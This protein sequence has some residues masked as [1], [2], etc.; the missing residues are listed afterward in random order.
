[1]FFSA[2]HLDIKSKQ[3][4]ADF[5]SIG[6]SGKLIICDGIGSFPESGKVSKLVVDKFISG[7]YKSI[8]EII[9]DLDSITVK[10]F[11]GGTTLITA[12]RILKSDKVKFEYLGNGGIIQLHGDFAINP[13]TEYPYRYGE[14][15]IPHV[16][17]SGKLTRHISH[18]SNKQEHR[19]TKLEV[20]L[21]YHCGDI[22]ILFSDGLSSLEENIILKDK[23]S[24]YWRYEN[25]AIQKVL[26]ALHVF[27]RNN[28]KSSNFEHDLILFNENILKDLKT[29]GALD[30]DASL[31]II[32]TKSVVEYYIESNG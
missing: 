23:E 17:P 4:C 18:N 16:S 11:E 8:S 7:D 24:R 30:D 31:G 22:V 5:S 13:N 10:N 3:D 2:T 14:L 27:L 12:Q 15:M 25:P 29:E 6:E 32:I 26:Q 21:N 9:L 1:M 28:C 19:T 20:D